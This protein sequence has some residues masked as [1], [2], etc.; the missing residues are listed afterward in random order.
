MLKGV[1]QMTGFFSLLTNMTQLKFVRPERY[2]H[3]SAMIVKH[4]QIYKSIFTWNA[5]LITSVGLLNY[6]ATLVQQ[7]PQACT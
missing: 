2:I 4:F 5:R 7:S 6:S 1:A 3:D